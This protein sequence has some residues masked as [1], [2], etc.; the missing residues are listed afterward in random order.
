MKTNFLK[1]IAT[2]TFD[3]FPPLNLALLAIIKKKKVSFTGHSKPNTIAFLLN[4]KNQQGLIFI[5]I[6]WHHMMLKP[7][8]KIYNGKH[9]PI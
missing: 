3:K 7:G 1:W 2:K 6:L 5:D 9:D 8:S 4:Y